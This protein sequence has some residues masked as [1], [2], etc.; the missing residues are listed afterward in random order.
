[1][2]VYPYL[3]KIM[4]ENKKF[5]KYKLEFQKKTIKQVIQIESEPNRTQNL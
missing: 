1:M 2:M 4:E 5:E 3:K